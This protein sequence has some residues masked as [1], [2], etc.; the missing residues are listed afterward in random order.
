MTSKLVPQNPAR[1]LAA[2]EEPAT[3]PLNGRLDHGHDD[4]TVAK[5][6]RKPVAHD[7]DRDI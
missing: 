7:P 5:A 4:S 2:V 6:H 1:R 3:I